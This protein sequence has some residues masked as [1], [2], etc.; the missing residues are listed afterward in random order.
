MKIPEPSENAT[1]E[2]ISRQKLSDQVYERLW[3]KIRSGELA[4]GD[5][6]PSE[7]A[8]MERFG[9]GRPAVREALQMLASKGVITISHGERSRVNEPT[10]STALEQI[11]GIAKLMLSSEPAN[12]EHLKQVRKILEGGTVAIA[13]ASCTTADVDA[14]RAIVERQRSVIGEDRPFIEADIEFHIAL[15][16]VTGNPLLEAVTKAMLTWLFAYYKPLLHWAGREQ[17]TIK[18]H[19]G[20]VTLLAQHDVEG[21]ERLMEQHLNRSDPLYTSEPAVA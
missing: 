9:V 15:A 4:P 5:T 12:L 11:D 1:E 10:A 19:E 8:L 7:R 3:Q 17:T 20:I 14:L 16:R 2:P 18:E 6:I 13:A 21:A